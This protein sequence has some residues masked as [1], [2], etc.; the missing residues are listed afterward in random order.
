MSKETE[1]SKKPIFK[2]WW[3]WVIVVIAVL[4]VIGSQVGGN[5]SGPVSKEEAEA[6]DLKI[7]TSVKLA[8]NYLDYLFEQSEN[9]ENGSSTALDVYN[10]CKDIRDYMLQFSDHID[11]VEDSRAE[12]YKDTAKSYIGN[13][14]LIAS[15]MMAY[16]DEGSMEN[17]SSAQ[18]GIQLIPTYESLVDEARSEYLSSSGFSDLEIQGIID[19]SQTTVTV[20]PET[21]PTSTPESDPVKSNI[22]A[23][24]EAFCDTSFIHVSTLGGTTTVSLYDPEIV[25]PVQAAEDAGGA[26]DNW[27]DIKTS[28]VELSEALP[29]APSTTQSVIYLRESES[30]DIYLTVSSGKA[31]FDAFDE[32][33]VY[34]RETISLEE[35][36][37]ITNGMTY[38]EVVSIVGSQGTLLSETDLGIGSEYATTMWK[39]EGEGSTGATAHIMFQD[40]KVVNKSQIGLE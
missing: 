3:F 39:W 31:L 9:I 4:A 11:E 34:N 38:D 20:T 18:E 24:F 40:G 12:E 35:F 28:L 14:R 29:L 7:Y 33:V 21:A 27:G 32:P 15:D 1:N 30:G 37:Q 16:I 5:N 10:T 13:I 2:K 17:L 23:T 22:A 6:N 26:P 19:P 25:D 8:R 36:N